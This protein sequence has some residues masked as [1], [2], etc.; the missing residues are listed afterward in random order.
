MEKTPEWFYPFSVIAGFLVV[1]LWAAFSI[2]M[3]IILAVIIGIILFSVST[4]V[5]FWGLALTAVFFDLLKELGGK[6]D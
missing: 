2:K 6:H 4:L 5:V 1:A 3:N